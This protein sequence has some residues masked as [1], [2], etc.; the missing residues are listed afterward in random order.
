M[1]SQ[2]YATEKVLFFQ[3]FLYRNENKQKTY[4][5][6]KIYGFVLVYMCFDWVSVN[7]KV[8]WLHIVV[9]FRI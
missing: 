3:N 8:R 5:N 2:K 1:Q 7:V 4:T 9:V 6:V